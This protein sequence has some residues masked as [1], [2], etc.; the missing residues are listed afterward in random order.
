MTIIKQFQNKRI[1][2]D[3]G[4]KQWSSL[5]SDVAKAPPNSNEARH[6]KGGPIGI[7]LEMIA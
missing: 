3:E 6:L 5:V 2:R 7:P 1:I 4:V